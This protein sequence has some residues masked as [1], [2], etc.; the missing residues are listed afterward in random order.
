[1]ADDIDYAGRL[2]ELL[3]EPERKPRPKHHPATLRRAAGLVAAGNSDR[4]SMARPMTFS[5][6]RFAAWLMKAGIPWPRLPAGALALDDDTFR[7]TAKAY[8]AVAPLRELRHTLGELRLESLAVGDDGRNRCLLSAFASR[9]GRNQP[10][11][12]RFIF[13]PSVWLRGLIKPAAGM[14]VA[15]VDW[16]QQEFGI[17]VALSGD[18]AMADAYASGDPI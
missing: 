18:R 13:G 10:S 6:E 15:Y 1:V 17:A 11:N 14:A 7:Q 8:P 5:A 2:W 4:Y 9:T 16:E 3:R 12:A